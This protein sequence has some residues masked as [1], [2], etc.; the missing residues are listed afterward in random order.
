MSLNPKYPLY[1][2]ESTRLRSFDNWPRGLTQRKCD[3]VDAGFYYIGFSDKVVCFCCGG[4]LKDWL[5]ENQPWEEH[6]RWYQF[7]PYVLLVKG[8]LYVQ[9]IISKECEINELDEQS[10]PNDLEDDEKRKCETL[11]ETLQLTCK[12]CLIE[13]LNTCFTPCGHAIACAK[14]VL[15]MNSK[16]PICRAVYRKV[17]RLYF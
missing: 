10:V 9:R 7:C 1:S 8:Y 11:S 2:T 16:C 12:I 5:P 15:S 14:C 17:I 6:A 13:K 3:M 4:G